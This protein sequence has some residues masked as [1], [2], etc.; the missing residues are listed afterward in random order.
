MSKK[1]CFIITPIGKENNPIR[2]RIDKVIDK[3]ILPEMQDCYE[4]KVAHR[5]Y[6]IGSITKQILDLIYESDLV[7]ANLTG[8]NPNVMYELGFR[9]TIGSPVIIIAEKGTKLPFD[10]YSERA[11]FYTTD[12]AGILKARRELREYLDNLNYND[13]KATGPIYTLLDTEKLR[14]IILSLNYNILVP[15]H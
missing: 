6:K 1:T 3:I 13:Q 9:H 12:P 5:I 2:R 7:I 8:A 10:T 4:I 14:N 11:L 15:E